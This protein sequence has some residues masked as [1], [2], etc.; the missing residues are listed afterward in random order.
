MSRPLGILPSQSPNLA[1]ELTRS[2]DFPTIDPAPSSSPDSIPALKTALLNTSLP[3]FE[4]YRAMF[5]LRDFGS[6]SKE[7]VLAL[8]EG[9]GDESALFRHEVAYIFGQLCSPYSV[10]S[11]LTVLRDAKEE[12]MVRHEAAEALGGIASDGSEVDGAELPEGGVLAILREWA[13]KQDAPVVVRESC[14]VAIDMWEVS[15]GSGA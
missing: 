15:L 9:F 3:L 14:Q 2:P 12:E 5:A 11:L 10:P 13:V 1:I 6:A 4:R 8:A 7:S